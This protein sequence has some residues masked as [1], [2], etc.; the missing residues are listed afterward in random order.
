M[1][2]Q[3]QE[4]EIV[5]LRTK[6]RMGLSE[7]GNYFE[8][9]MALIEFD[10]LIPHV[11]V[12]HNGAPLIFRRKLFVYN[13]KKFEHE[14]YRVPTTPESLSFL[15]AIRGEFS[16]C[17][18]DWA[19]SSLTSHRFGLGLALVTDKGTLINPPKKIIGKGI[20]EI[21]KTISKIKLN[22]EL[23]EGVY[24]LRNGFEEGYN[25]I[26]FI[27]QKALATESFGKALEHFDDS[28]N[29]E[30]ILKRKECDLN[31]KF[32]IKQYYSS[33]KKEFDF[34]SNYYFLGSFPKNPPEAMLVQVCLETELEKLE[35]VTMDSSIRPFFYGVVKNKSEKEFEK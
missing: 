35:Y 24:V 29:L 17:N 18:L 32:D 6:Q 14:D 28:K 27:P 34:W 11:Q 16:S 31:P 7:I 10:K 26:S 15:S 13:L 2:E 5:Y 4:Y 1:A 25:D 33:R 21:K 3:E 8:G 19:P 30:K 12:V 22:S 23:K 9:D 20:D